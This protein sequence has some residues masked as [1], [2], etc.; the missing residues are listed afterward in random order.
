MKASAK[1]CFI[2]LVDRSQNSSAAFTFRP[3]PN[4]GRRPGTVFPPAPKKAFC[5]DEGRDRRVFTHTT[6][7]FLLGKTLVQR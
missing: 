2:F 6:E 1:F 3:Q 7:V 5:G 4:L